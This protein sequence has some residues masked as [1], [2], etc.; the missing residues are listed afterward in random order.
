MFTHEP[1]V[2]TAFIPCQI[3]V[4]Y[5]TVLSNSFCTSQMKSVW[6]VTVHSVLTDDINA[7]Y[8]LVQMQI[9]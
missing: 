8:I 3:C 5:V 1:C 6:S 4:F 7:L 2:K 9:H